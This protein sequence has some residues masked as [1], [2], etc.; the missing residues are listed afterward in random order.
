MLSGLPELTAR[1]RAISV[2]ATIVVGTADRIVPVAA[3]RA[4]SREIPGARLVEFER[5]GHLLPQRNAS[6]L[7]ELIRGASAA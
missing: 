2:S 6:E 1:L 7:A 4:L 5:G 3:A